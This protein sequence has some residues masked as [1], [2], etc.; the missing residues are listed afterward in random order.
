MDSFKELH[1]KSLGYKR[2]PGMLQNKL[3]TAIQN[4]EIQL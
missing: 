2:K 4:L 3:Q 1:T